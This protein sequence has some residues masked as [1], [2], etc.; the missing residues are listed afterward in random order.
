LSTDNER[1]ND[2]LKSTSSNF[3]GDIRLTPS[4]TAELVGSYRE[5]EKRVPGS[6]SYP[7]PKYFTDSKNWLLSPGLRFQNND[8]NI[9]AFYSREYFSSDDTGFLGAISYPR[10]K[11]DEIN[12]QFDYNGIDAVTLTLGGLY[13][14]ETIRKGTYYKALDQTG[15]FAQALWQ[16]NE[17]FEIRGGLR[18]DSYS[19]YEDSW[20]WNA[21]L[22]Y[23]VPNTDL[24]IFT[25]IASAYAPPSGQDIGYDSNK[26]ANGNTVDT[27]ILPE[28]SLSY[29]IGMRQK[30]LDEKLQWSAVIFRNN[31]DN[32]IR[33][34]QYDDTDFSISDTLNAK[35][36]MTEGVEFSLDYKLNPKLSLNF[37]YTYLT[38]VYDS[39]ITDSKNYEEI[40]LSYRPRH[41][42]QFS[43][44]YE[45]TDALNLGLSVIGQCDRQRDNW[46]AYNSD[47]EDYV[48]LNCVAEYQLLETLSLLGRIDN[49]LDESYATSYD[50]PNL[51]TSIY[52]GVRVKF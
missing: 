29:E 19:D 24:S 1:P 22:I 39:Y 3:R 20:T 41:S 18:F 38:A 21:E 37:A 46:Q 7:T 33:Y 13:R 36:A 11:T 35:K 51:G 8:V 40:R 50:Y 12:L 48:V 28:E 32:Y 5:H 52:F 2:G 44:L 42:L 23:F 31:I 47:T 17:A 6:A 43:A 34:V 4:L 16:I 27:P 30:I 49:L 15:G 9:H 25:K 14:D 45:A 26:D 10:L